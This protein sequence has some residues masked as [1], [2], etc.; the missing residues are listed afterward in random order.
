LDKIVPD[1]DKLFVVDGIEW[2]RRKN[3]PENEENSVC[4]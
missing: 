2:K 1:N 3:D 4:H